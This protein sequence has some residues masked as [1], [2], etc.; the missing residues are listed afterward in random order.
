MGVQEA[1]RQPKGNMASTEAVGVSVEDLSL[2]KLASN[3]EQTLSDEQWM[4]YV[5]ESEAF[6]RQG[7]CC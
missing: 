6:Q 5:T 1:R 3:D 4:A 2:K 7:I